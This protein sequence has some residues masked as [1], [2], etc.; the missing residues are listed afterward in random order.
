MPRLQDAL[1]GAQTSPPRPVGAA[2]RVAIVAGGAGALGS[3]VLEHALSSG[4][5]ASVRALALTPIAPGLRSFESVSLDA[6]DGSW[7]RPADTAFVV[8]DRE[9]RAGGRE[10]AFVRPLPEQLPQLAHALHASGVHHLIV[11]LPHAPAL[12]P[13]ALKRG[14]ASLDEH[15]VAALAFEHT[16]FVRTAQPLASPA[17]LRGRPQRLAAW[18]LSQL[19]WMV[20]QQQ[21]AVRPAKVASLVVEL[22]RALPQALPGTRVVP[23]ELV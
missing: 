14:L 21:Q 22:A 23:P 5:F 4:V 16:V 12:L 18:M 10:D 20:P 6:L 7:A 19:H 17:V 2:Q 9:R 3:A 1:R 13:E 8:F 15:A 11:V